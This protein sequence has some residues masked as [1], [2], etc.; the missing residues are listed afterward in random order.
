MGIRR[1]ALRWCN[2]PIE[3]W[4]ETTQTWV[5]DFLRARI[6]LVDRFLSNFNKPTRRRQLFA[7]HDAVMPGSLIIR[8]PGTLD[9]YLVGATRV[10]ARKGKPYV[11]VTILQLA[12]DAPGG[13][14][15]LA[16]ITRKVPMGP[17]S[18]PGWLVETEILTTYVDL[19]FR[20]SSNEPDTH[21]L[22]IENFLFYLTRNHQLQMWDYIH[23]HGKS[24]R[25]IDFFP[26]SGFSSGRMDEEEDT[27]VDMILRDKAVD[28]TYDKV[29]QKWVGGPRDYNVT[30]VIIRDEGFAVWT[31]ESED[32]FTVYFQREHLGVVPEATTMSLIYQGR[33]RV[34]RQVTTQSGGRQWELR[35]N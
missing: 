29:Q 27:R 12:T 31:D 19:E 23:L 16:K 21:E 13:S 32:Y 1:S 4:D 34:V 26:D 15:G 30:G 28:K 2:E 33:E 10:D 24:Y 7:A 20:T 8:H 18:D 25:V 5:P 14:S 3:A 35:C 11:G 22:K 9:V 6:D 17:P